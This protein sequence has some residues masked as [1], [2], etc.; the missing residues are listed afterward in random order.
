MPHGFV[1]IS[2]GHCL[3][4]IGFFI[5]LVVE[6]GFDVIQPLEARAG[7]DIRLL[8]PQWGDRITMMGNINADVIA[9]GNEEQI[10]HEVVSKL[11]AAM[12]HGGYIYHIDHS[13]PPTVSLANYS[14]LIRLLKENGVYR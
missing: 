3:V 9:A 2:R 10:R 11:Q 5:P 6:A 8:K 1:T 13:V 12:Q 4:I 7:N 14:L